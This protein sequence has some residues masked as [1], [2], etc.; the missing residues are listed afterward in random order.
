M[1]STPLL[2]YP[3]VVLGMHPQES[4]G[5]FCAAPRF[6]RNSDAWDFLTI[7]GL[8]HISGV[9]EHGLPSASRSPFAWWLS[10]GCLSVDVSCHRYTDT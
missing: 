10:L 1:K 7:L 8:T 4:S 2:G 5:G 6:A 9:S 3:G